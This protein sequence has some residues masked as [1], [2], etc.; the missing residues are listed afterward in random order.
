MNRNGARWGRSRAFWVWM[1]FAAALFLSAACSDVT[2]PRV[3][4]EVDDT[5]A[6]DS[7]ERAG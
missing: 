2:A 7:T 5:L 3:T 4:K 1:V 6:Q